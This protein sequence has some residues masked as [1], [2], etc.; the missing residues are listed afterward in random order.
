M[1]ILKKNKNMI[2]RMHYFS[3]EVKPKFMSSQGAALSKEQW[4]NHLQNHILF[5]PH[6]YTWYKPMADKCDQIYVWCMRK[7]TM[8]MLKNMI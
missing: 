1:K 6:A 4:K 7:V 3:A 5:K 8:I 2:R